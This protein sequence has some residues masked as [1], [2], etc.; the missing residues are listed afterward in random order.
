MTST[1]AGGYDYIAVGLALV[2]AYAILLWLFFRK[3]SGASDRKVDWWWF[4]LVGPPALLYWYSTRS[5][6]KALLSKRE[7]FG[8]LFVAVFMTMIFLWKVLR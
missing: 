1:I 5:G 8:W 4:L 2:I 6:R 7:S 3:F